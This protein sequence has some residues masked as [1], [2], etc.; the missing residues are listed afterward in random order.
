MPTHIL[1]DDFAKL[2]NTII[3]LR[4]TVG[5][6]EV[7]DPREEAGI[8]A[9]AVK[10]DNASFLLD[11]PKLPTGA[12]SSPDSGGIPMSLEGGKS[13]SQKLSVLL[14]S[15]GINFMTN[16]LSLCNNAGNILMKI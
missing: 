14:M 6:I 8:H 7:F 4:A 15:V 2:D 5:G 9:A 3:I 13:S 12:L 11:I 10:A 1:G 16:V